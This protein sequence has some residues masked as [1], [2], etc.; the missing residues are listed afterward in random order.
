MVEAL[1]NRLVFNRFNTSHRKCYYQIMP[2]AITSPEVKIDIRSTPKNLNE[3]GKK[4]GVAPQPLGNTEVKT[5][6]P[7]LISS[8]IDKYA[9]QKQELH[10]YLEQ[11]GE[12]LPP[13]HKFTQLVQKVSEKLGIPGKTDLIAMDTEEI[14]AFYDPESKTVVLTRGWCRYLIEQGLSLKEDHMAAV[15]GHELEHARVLGDDYVQRLKS[16]YLERFKNIQNHAEEYRADADAMRRLSKAGYNPRAMIDIFRTTSLTHGRRDLKHPEQI[17]RIRQLEDKLADDEHPLSNTSKE[18]TPID[19]EMLTWITTDSDVYNKTEKLIHSSTNELA[20]DL[21]TVKTQQQFWEIYDLKRHIDRVAAAKSLTVEE[22]QNLERLAMELMVY[23]AFCEKQAFIDGQP[24]EIDYKVIDGL[25]DEEGGISKEEAHKISY[26]KNSYLDS[27]KLTNLFKGNAFRQNVSR[28]LP[29]DISLNSA[30]NDISAIGGFVDRAIKGRLN[31]LTT[32]SLR[33]NERKYYG[34]LQRCFESGQVSKDLLLTLYSSIDSQYQKELQKASSQQNQERGLRDNIRDT[35]NL[36]DLRDANIGIKVLDQAK[37]ALATSL[38]KAPDASLE[39]INLFGTAISHDTG[40]DKQGAGILAK[41][42]LKQENAS[43]WVKYLKTLD[44]DSLKRITKGIKTLVTSG[45]GLRFSPFRSLHQSYLASESQIKSSEPWGIYANGVE[46]GIDATGLT[47][48]KMLAARE[49]YLRG[50]PPEFRYD[51]HNRLPPSQI[52][53]TM[54]EWDLAV[55]GKANYGLESERAEWALIKYLDQVKVGGEINS[56]LVEY[57][58]KYAEVSYSTTNLTPEQMSLMIHHSLWDNTHLQKMINQGLNNWF[59]K[60]S[61]KGRLSEKMPELAEQERQDIAVTLRDTYS[62]FKNNPLD[63]EKIEKYSEIP[64]PEKISSWLLEVLIQ[65]AE[66][67]GTPVKDASIQSLKQIISEGI[68]L[69]Y[70]SI[71]KETKS[72]IGEYSIG[73]IDGL[74][75]ILRRTNIADKNRQNL[76][77]NFQLLNIVSDVDR[78]EAAKKPISEASIK[79]VLSK[80]GN[81]SVEWVTQNFQQSD[82]RDLVLI[83]LYEFAGEDQKAKFDLQI[84]NQLTEYPD[85]FNARHSSSFDFEAYYARVKYRKNATKDEY[86]GQGKL[87]K[88]FPDLLKRRHSFATLAFKADRTSAVLYDNWGRGISEHDGSIYQEY[89]ANRLLRNESI[90]FNRELPFNQRMQGLT[91]AAPYRSVVRDIHLEMLLREEL[92]QTKDANERVRIGRILLPLFTEKSSL[93]NPLA[94]QVFRSELAINP[95]LTQDFNGYIDELTHY[96][97]EPSL[98]RNYF[99]NQFENSTPLTVKQLKQITSMRIS[100]EGKKTKKDEDGLI[101][102]ESDS[103]PM[104][105]VID[106][107]GELNREERIKTALWLLGVNSDKPK[108]ALKM[109]KEF[110]GHLD[111]LP[112]AV[113]VSTYDEK[114]VTYKRLFLGAEGIVDLETVKPE[115][116]PIAEK[117]RKEFIEVLARNML[118]D[119]MPK[120]DLFR[121]IFSTVIESSDPSHASRILTKL[122]NK[123]SEAKIRGKE[124]PPEEVVALGLNELG[125]IGKK[126][127]QSL[128]ELDWVPDSYKR[129]LRRSQSEGEV[130]PKRALLMLAEDAG[131]TEDD[132]LI[133]IVSFDD[134]I[135]AASNKQ[136]VLLTVEINDEKV[137]LSKG[138]HKVVGKFKRP[139]AQKTENIKHD[140]GVLKSI[141][142]V[143]NKEG[144]SDALPRDFSAQISDAVKRELEFTREKQFSGEIRKDL[145]E[146]NSKRR[147]KVSVPDIYFASE[148][149]IMESVA[150]GISLRQ[151]KDFREAGYNQLLESGYGAFSEREIDQTVVVEALSQLITT[152]NVHA[153]LHPGNIFLDQQGNLTLIDLGMHEKLNSAQRLNTISLIT[154]L[155][156]GSENYVKSTLKNLGWDLG[157]VKLDL[158]RFKFAQNTMQLLRVSQRASVPMPE[159]LGSIILAT[160]K[161][162]TYTKGFGNAELF[163]MLI[164]AVDKKE[165]PRIIS[166]LLQSGGKNF[167]RPQQY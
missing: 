104:T 99:L 49:F 155:A 17:E 90:I 35:T 154:G 132:A 140:L 16:S 23:D 24:I 101:E 147:L 65:D 166:H 149:V 54:E 86:L 122:I 85:R 119:S 91:D 41:I 141:L 4:F 27:G 78:K 106:K 38:I 164:N 64:T 58:R 93:K 12:M 88:N 114:E 82:M 131:L 97:S 44:K 94:I 1:K 60:R 120:A 6:T 124:L 112:D 126:V 47:A 7:E 137:G 133:K 43:E 95:Q 2:N 52:N 144:Y 80:H 143:L 10:S 158:K 30:R 76:I 165:A 160:S 29:D 61:P 45:N 148:D 117:Q 48:I 113:A 37:F 105:F 56:Q 50:Y 57:A 15:L 134:L 136:A 157:D 79:V 74:L 9:K 11:I 139:S 19:K 163:R 34:E 116:L 36:L 161:L 103:A 135:G 39:A 55:E 21:Q 92:T 59:A 107:L 127:S 129:T 109:E 96:M 108:A 8:S 110:D 111:S 72:L 40:L 150:P 118:P 123:F 62:L 66:S 125:V 31:L 63:K 138:K 84:K 53:L 46:Y 128:A 42:I 3:F 28:E 33:E 22:N 159:L 77:E 130:V 167:L 13:D 67:K 69:D 87:A 51:F 162:T 25:S 32:K 145:D 5:Q 151:Y 98:A 142:E 68:F 115:G 153:D 75:Q 70:S 73:D 100:P 152:G 20:R 156:T 81:G 18:L 89:I 102:T 83:G 26:A 121:N 146:R 14:N 71:S